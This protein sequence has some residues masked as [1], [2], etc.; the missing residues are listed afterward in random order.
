MRAAANERWGGTTLADR[1]VV[2]QGAGKVGSSLARSLTADGAKVAVSDID[3]ARV[4]TL[5]KELKV[6]ALAPDEVVAAKVQ[7]RAES[8]VFPKL[9]GP[10]AAVISQHAGEA[11]EA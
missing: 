11:S 1:R 7:R 9:F 6:E 10:A 4:A 5:V 8:G 3:E 2:I